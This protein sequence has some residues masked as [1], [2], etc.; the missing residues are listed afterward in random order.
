[1]ASTTAFSLSDHRRDIVGPKDAL[2]DDY[3]TLDPSK[4]SKDSEELRI[5]I[6]D[7]MLEKIGQWFTEENGQVAIYDANN[8]TLEA[9]NELR[10]FFKTLDVHC[11]FIGQSALEPPFMCVRAGFD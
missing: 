6:K 10:D 5:K 2:P 1:M 7:S 9:R 11:F 8:I 3:F 4:R